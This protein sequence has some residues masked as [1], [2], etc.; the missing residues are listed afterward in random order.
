MEDVENGFGHVI[1]KGM[2][3]LEGV[4]LE[5]KFDCDSLY[6]I[7][8]KPKSPFFFREIMVFKSMQLESKKG[9]FELNNDELLFIIKYIELSYQ[10]SIFLQTQ[11]LYLVFMFSV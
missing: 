8:K 5:R 6:T 4:F 2:K 1:K 7:P 11:Y 10:K 3:H 9:H